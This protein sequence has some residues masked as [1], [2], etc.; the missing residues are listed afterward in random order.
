MTLDWVRE[1]GTG[2][3]YRRGA[4]TRLT[5]YWVRRSCPAVFD[6][7]ATSAGATANRL[8]TTRT[9]AASTTI[10]HAERDTDDDPHHRH[11][12][13]LPAHGRA[14][15]VVD[16]P[17]VLEQS[18]LA[19]TPRDAHDQQ[20]QERGRAEQRQ[21][22]PQDQREVDRLAEVDQRRRH[23]GSLGVGALVQAD[24]V[25]DGGLARGARSHTGQYGDGL[26]RP[27]GALAPAVVGAGGA[28]R[29]QV[30]GQGECRAPA[31]QAELAG[32][33]DRPHHLHR[34]RARAACRR[35]HRHTDDGPHVRVHLVQCRRPQGDLVVAGGQAARHRRQ[36]QGPTD[37][38]ARHG[39]DARA[40]DGDLVSGAERDAGDG[41]VVLQARHLGGD[42]AR[43]L[44]VRDQ[45][46][47]VVAV[48]RGGGDEMRQAGAE[49]RR[50]A[51]GQTARTVPNRAVP[52]GTVATPRPFSSAWRTPITALG[53]APAAATRPTMTEG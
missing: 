4:A 10:S 52:T 6:R 16:E 28:R 38:V 41:R 35:L 14:H 19:P 21:H 36:E 3:A 32:R 18:D 24:E 8:E 51:Q 2:T 50:R 26:A 29:V 7:A 37:G 42:V 47:V 44:L 11:R 17:E 13:R 40:V 15:L 31:P 27:A 20:V 33:R 49:D 9:P 48:Q 23:R 1:L 34:R 12:A 45:Q 22:E 30:A 25:G 39:E 46:V 53:G 5:D 43:S